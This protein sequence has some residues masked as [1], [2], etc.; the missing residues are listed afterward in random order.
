MTARADIRGGM[1]VR[2]LTDLPAREQWLVR[3]LRDWCEGPD[4]QARVWTA[5]AG[6]LG[7]ARA[8]T[9]LAEFETTLSI[10]L[11]Q[12]R[13]RFCRHSAGCPCAGLDE[14]LLAHFVT[15]ASSENEEDALLMAMLLVPADR[16]WPLV[17]SARRLGLEIGRM[18]MQGSNLKSL[19][20]T[21]A[22]IS[23]M[24]H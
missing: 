1:P 24:H 2:A 22:P 7:A 9:V 4:G 8:R 12:G 14:T 15:I 5:L 3:A 21:S 18:T 10:L 20:P 6:T 16:M 19:V 17:S 11:G 23:R 13:R